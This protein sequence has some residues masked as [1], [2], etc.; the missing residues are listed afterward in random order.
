MNLT[1]NQ[2]TVLDLLAWAE[3]MGTELRPSVEFRF[4]DP[5]SD[6]EPARVNLTTGDPCADDDSWLSVWATGTTLAEAAAEAVRRY[7]DRAIELTNKPQPCG[8]LGGCSPD[9]RSSTV[10]VD[11]DSSEPLL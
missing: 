1:N 6:D 8:E 10:S 5:T 2:Q 3:G 7:T 4:R 11:F 9:L